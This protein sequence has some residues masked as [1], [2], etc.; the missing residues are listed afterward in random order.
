MPR[1]ANP[2]PTSAVEQEH[3]LISV[4]NLIDYNS[5]IEVLSL[6]TQRIEEL[7]EEEESLTVDE[8][9]IRLATINNLDSV[10]ILHG[11][12]RASDDVDADDELEEEDDESDDDEE[13]E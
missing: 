10:L 4:L 7:T 11:V 13:D 6:T 9:A 8:L 3:S 2:Q 5:C 12:E 1:K